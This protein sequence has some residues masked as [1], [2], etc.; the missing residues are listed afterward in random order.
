MSLTSAIHAGATPNSRNVSWRWSNPRPHGNNIAG[1]AYGEGWVV[2]VG[3]RGQIYLS[4]NLDEWIP[5]DGKTTNDLRSATFFGGKIIITGEGGTILTADASSPRPE[6]HRT[7]LGT[8]DWLE[9]V[10]ASSRLVVAAGD[11]G[12]IYTSSDGSLWRLQRQAFSNWL[13][14]VAFGNNLFVAVGEDGFVASSSDGAA[15]QRQNSGVAEHLNQ[16]AWVQNRFLAFGEAGRAITSADGRDWQPIS[17]GATNALYAIAA[18]TSSLVAA[19]ER[20]VRLQENGV[21]SD[22]IRASNRSFAAPDWTYLS[23]LW[24]GS[25]FLLGGRSGRVL[26]G[27]KTN[28]TG[29]MLWVD[30]HDSLRNWIWDLT[31]TPEFYIAVGDRATVM[32]S[33]DGIDWTLELVPNSL[34]NAIFLGVGG[35]TNLFL[36]VG[37]QGRAMTS[38]NGVIWDVVRMPTSN[39]LQGVAALNN[40]FVVTGG[41]GTILTSPNATNWTIRTASTAAFLSSVTSSPRGWVASGSLGTILQ[42]SDGMSWTQRS[43]GTTNWIYR[44]RFLGGQFVGVGQNGTILTSLDGANWTRR[45]SGTSEWLNDVARVGE[46][47]FIAGTHGTVLRSS[48]GIQWENIGTITRKSLF[49]LAAFEGQLIAAGVEGVILRSQVIPDQS[50]ILIKSYRRQSGQDAFLFLG[51]PDQRFTLDHSTNLPNWTPGTQL[52]FLDSSGTLLY[53]ENLGAVSDRQFFRATLR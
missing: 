31:R 38:S 27:F 4:R 34:T 40:L 9:G 6:F 32:T 47:F 37:N 44:M 11:N 45:S 3:E 41:A 1:M 48:D 19:G 52:E 35:T 43:S 10:A 46:T 36:A 29:P 53:L 7:D 8:A 39:D 33:E 18:N 42:S 28:S 13:R 15:W 49:A 12:A 22:E 51:K 16:V 30:R 2:Q 25:L 20:E 23:S 24:D 14:A 26:E 50:P 17:T 5:C 21:W